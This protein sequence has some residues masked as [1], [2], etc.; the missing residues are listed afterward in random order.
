MTHSPPK[1]ISD[2]QIPRLKRLCH[3][4]GLAFFVGG[5]LLEPALGLFVLGLI[6]LELS[7]Q[8]EDPRGRRFD[9]AQETLDNYVNEILERVDSRRPLH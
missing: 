1:R 3:W 2:L 5:A 7:N 4:A 6:L 9:A 8:R